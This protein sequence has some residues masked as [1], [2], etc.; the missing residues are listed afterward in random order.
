MSDESFKDAE[1][2]S[3]LNKAAD[4]LL[5][6]AIIDPL[7][8]QAAGELL[9]DEA[10]DAKIDELLSSPEIDAMLENVAKD[11]ADDIGEAVEELLAS[12]PLVKQ[13]AEAQNVYITKAEFDAFV[14]R[15]EKVFKHAGFKL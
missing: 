7:V 3:D 15:V 1:P 10:L 12:A 13:V 8:H 5:T 9:S 4:L 11:A 6:D 2:V 14:A